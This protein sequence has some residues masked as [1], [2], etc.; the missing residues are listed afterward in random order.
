MCFEEF[1][2]TVVLVVAPV[3]L[4]VESEEASADYVHYV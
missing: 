3:I 1:N 2:D 4:A